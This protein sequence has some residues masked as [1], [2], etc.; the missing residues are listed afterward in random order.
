MANDRKSKSNKNG[1]GDSNKQ[2]YNLIPLFIMREAGLEIRE[3]PKIH[4]KEPTVEDNSIFFLY[5]YLRIPLTLN[6]I[7]SIF[8]NRRTTTHYLIDGIPVLITPEGPTWNP[9]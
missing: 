9:H 7:F 8:P 1:K 6:V 4:V 5:A 3:I 2:L